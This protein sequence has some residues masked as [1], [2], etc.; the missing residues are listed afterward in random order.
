VS[1]A[2]DLERRYRRW[3]RWY[4]EA[5]RREYEDE[6]LGVLVASAQAGQR[7][8]DSMECL[9][10]MANGLRLRLR[11]TVSRSEPWTLTAVRLMIVGAALELAAAVTILATA[12][13]LTK[14][15]AERSPGPHDAQWQAAVSGRVERVALAAVVA[16]VVWLGLAWAVGRGHR[17]ARV[18]F[19][20][21]FGVNLF[22]LVDGLAAGSAVYARADLAVGTILCLVQLAAVVLVFERQA[23]KIPWIRS[24][25]GRIAGRHSG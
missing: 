21:L 18:A 12:G 20:I 5:F 25:A 6:L 1:G 19:A 24:A 22:G 4:P 3:L 13:D 14:R 7:R 8:P 2:D 16:V 17:R 10:L 15:A 9:D 11:P 23:D